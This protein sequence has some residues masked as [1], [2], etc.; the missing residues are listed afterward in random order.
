MN[1]KYF[2]EHIIQ[3]GRLEVGDITFWADDHGLYANQFLRVTESFITHARASQWKK[4]KLFLCSHDIKPGDRFRLPDDYML[5]AD[6][7]YGPDV[8]CS[9]ISEHA[10]H[11]ME[12]AMGGH[13]HSGVLRDNDTFKVIEEISHDAL[14]VKQGDIF[15][16]EDV[17]FIVTLGNAWDSDEDIIQK[18]EEEWLKIKLKKKIDNDTVIS[19]SIQIKGPCCHFH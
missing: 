4:F 5:L 13:V 15:N 14:W 6:G 3:E 18:T 11:F 10:F 1:K 19:K 2:A 16:E 7:M 12:P 17:R 8:T 9:S